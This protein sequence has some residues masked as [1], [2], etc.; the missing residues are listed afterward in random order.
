[1]NYEINFKKTSTRR[2]TKTGVAFPSA[3][4]RGM[5]KRVMLMHSREE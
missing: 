3:P 2:S 4:K 5:E 1:M